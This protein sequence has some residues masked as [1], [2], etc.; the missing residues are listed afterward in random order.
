MPNVAAENGLSRADE[1]LAEVNSA[2]ERLNRKRYR[3]VESEYVSY[4]MRHELYPWYRQKLAQVEKHGRGICARC[5]FSVGCVGLGVGLFRA[6]N[7]L[8]QIER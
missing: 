5:G 4:V 7:F 8:A 1:V 3:D 2:S 6:P